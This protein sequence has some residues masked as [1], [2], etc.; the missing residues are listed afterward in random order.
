MVAIFFAASGAVIL[1]RNRHGHAP[2]R[3]GRVSRPLPH[4][5]LG[6][7]QPGVQGQDGGSPESDLLALTVSWDTALRALRSITV[8]PGDPNESGYEL[9]GTAEA[10]AFDGPGLAAEDYANQTDQP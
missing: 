6:R 4:D 8:A 1:H 7:H 9:Y 10:R 5:H 2:P 3:N